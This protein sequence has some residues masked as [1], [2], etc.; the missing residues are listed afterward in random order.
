MGFLD[1]LKNKTIQE[2]SPSASD[3]DESEV[4]GSKFGGRQSNLKAYGYV[5]HKSR[6][7]LLSMITN[8]KRPLELTELEDNQTQIAVLCFNAINIEL[9]DMFR[10][11]EGLYFRSR[12]EELKN[13]DIYK[14]YDWFE[15]FYGI[16]TSIFDNEEDVLFAWLEKVGAIRMENALTPKRRKKKKERTRD[17]C[18]DIL[19]LKIHFEKRNGRPS[20]NGIRA[21]QQLPS[22]VLEMTDEAEQL[23]SRVLMYFQTLVDE[24]PSLLEDNFSFDERRLI[25]ENVIGNFRASEF[26]KYTICAYANGIVDEEKKAGFLEESLKGSK[27]PIQKHMKRFKKKH[28]DL[29]DDLSINPLLIER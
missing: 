25:E 9:R 22:L 3:S 17:L 5:G 1:I 6:S 15:G 16:I 4:G 20:M 13:E 10:I 18:W 24:L 21:K 2:N 12:N 19:E 11:L 8:T 26:G 7:F 14:F 27:V 28:T 29:V 23:A